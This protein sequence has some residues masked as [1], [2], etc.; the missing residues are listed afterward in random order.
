MKKNWIMRSAYLVLAVLLISTVAVSGTFAKYTW[1]V[2]SAADS[3]QVAKFAFKVGT[4]V[5][6]GAD[7]TTISVDLFNTINEADTET[8]EANV[9]PA[10]G[11]I[12]PGTGGS[13]AIPVENLSEVDVAVSFTANIVNASNIPVEFS[14]DKA[15]WTAWNDAAIANVFTALNKDLVYANAED[16]DTTTATIYWRWVFGDP[17]NN[18]SDTALGFAANTE[19]VPSIS[20]DFT[21]KV[22]Q[23][24]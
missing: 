9:D 11:K 6:D 10:N 18:T 20:V 23:I 22:D 21:V 7:D 15:T 17:A 1:T 4:A 8:A 19:N 3:A 12:A 24:D 5:I 13:F 14:T 16:T 2:S